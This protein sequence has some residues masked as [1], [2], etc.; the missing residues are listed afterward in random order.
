MSYST[1]TIGIWIATLPY[2]RFYRQNT[3]DPLHRIANLASQQGNTRKLLKAIARWRAQKLTELQFISIAC[4]IVAAA[5]IG[6][7]SWNT[8]MDAYWLSHALW[9]ASL[10]LSI[11]GILLSA[12]QI[13][14]LH[15]LGP[16][17]PT[18]K[19]EHIETAIRC[20]SPLLLAN[21]NK[22]NLSLPNLNA[23]PRRKMVF[24]WQCPMMFMAYS[25]IS[26]LF[27]LTILVCTPLIRRQ[28]WNSGCNIA[29]MYLVIF[30]AGGATYVYCSFWIYRYVD[31]DS[32]PPEDGDE[33]DYD[34]ELPARDFLG[35]RMLVEAPENRVKVR[36]SGTAGLGIQA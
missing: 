10:V 16:L 17:P 14:V 15:A 5:V 3:I 13:A 26:F 23:T 18:S 21:P 31:L 30:G 36:S 1:A 33:E 28:E 22:L 2:Y 20:Y 32:V 6:A 9:H 19:P 35:P 8:I 24:T 4:A 27:G 29:I 11:L 12:Q 7:F 25:V 34:V